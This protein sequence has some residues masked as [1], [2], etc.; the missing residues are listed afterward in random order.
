MKAAT[1][2][3]LGLALS[4]QLHAQSVENIW[5]NELA[6]AYHYVDRYEILIDASPQE[7]WPRLLDLGSWM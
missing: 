2:C 7:V 4:T 6:N 3:A 1:A 5:D